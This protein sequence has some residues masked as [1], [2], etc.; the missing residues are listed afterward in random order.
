MRRGLA[1]VEGKGRS[2]MRR[3][4]PPANVNPEHRSLIRPVVLAIDESLHHPAIA[5]KVFVADLR[6]VMPAVDEGDDDGAG[7]RARGR[8][9]AAG[10]APELAED[11]V[12]L[13][14]VLDVTIVTQLDHA[15]GEDLALRRAELLDRTL[16]K[17]LLGTFQLACTVVH[18][19]TFLQ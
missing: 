16:P 1:V 17:E 10:H 5:G 13:P 4:A 11:F 14:D 8:I 12:A 7:A 18:A 15:N 9:P 2:L 19:G 3:L 6:A